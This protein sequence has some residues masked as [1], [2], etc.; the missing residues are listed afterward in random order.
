MLRSMCV[1]WVGIKGHRRRL[2]MS[3]K[4]PP[5]EEEA[6]RAAWMQDVQALINAQLEQMR[7]LVTSAQQTRPQPA[8]TAALPPPRGSRRPP[9][10]P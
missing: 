8:R 4:A 3:D 9:R 5:A 6:A 10:E 1:P 2:L 7:L